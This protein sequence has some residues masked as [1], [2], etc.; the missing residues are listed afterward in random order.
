MNN[1]VRINGAV[2]ETVIKWAEFGTYGYTGELDGQYFTVTGKRGEWVRETFVGK[3]GRAGLLADGPAVATETF[4]TKRAAL[5]AVPPRNGPNF[6]D[7]GKYAVLAGQHLPAHDE[8]FDLAQKAG[9][10]LDNLRKY[11][12]Q[13]R[14]AEQ[15]QHAVAE[16]VATFAEVAQ[17]NVA[18]VTA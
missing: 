7:A 11:V 16:L 13:V 10:A 18:E 12:A 5:E 9:E 3:Q 17:R 2:F 6:E 15:A 1:P 4:P 14:D 8:V